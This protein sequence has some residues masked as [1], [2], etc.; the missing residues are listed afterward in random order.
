MKKI[1]LLLLAFCLAFCGCEKS[2][3]NDNDDRSSYVYSDEDEI[4]EDTEDVKDIDASINDSMFK[5]LGK[6]P[7]HVEAMYGKMTESVWVDGPIYRFEDSDSWFA[8]SEYD[9][10][11]DNAYVPLGKCEM[12]IIDVDD[13]V[14]TSEE[15]ISGGLLASLSDSGISKGYEEMDGIVYYEIT[16]DE[17]Q[18]TI[19]E[20]HNGNISEDSGAY[21][22]L[23]ED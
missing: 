11:D 10:A 19:Y 6:T 3:E 5:A 8:F 4:E 13:F 18:I 14:E 21:V 23:L 2:A 16:H 22:R 20:D 9:F 7:E 1:F 12:I 17:Y 15:E